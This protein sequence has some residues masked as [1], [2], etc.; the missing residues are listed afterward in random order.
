[1]CFV[2]GTSNT[3]IDLIYQGLPRVPNEGEELY[4]KDFS[5]Q[6]GGG[7]P[8]TLINLG[9][10]G[11]PTRIQTTLGSDMFS[12]F[13][14][15]M[16]QENG[17]APLNLYEGNGIPV[18]V[19]TA[20]LTPGDRTFCSYSDNPTVTDE[21]RDKVYQAS[22]GARVALM[23]FGY[24]DVYQKL[25]DEG[26]TLVFDTGWDDEMSLSSYHEYL[27]LADYYTP[28]Q[29]E[30]LK[31]TGAATPEDAARV[32]GRYFER[33][34]VKLDK[35]GCLISEHGSPRIVPQIPCYT[36]RDSIGAGDAFLA[37]LIYGIYHGADFARS[38]L[39]GNITGGKCVTGVGCLSASCTEDELLQ[40]AQ[41]YLHFIE[42]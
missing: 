29:K 11:V 22:T 21:M 6:L 36:H 32:L 1:M 26:T 37:G 7:V 3:N 19:T 30:A 42:E 38:V 18:N 40:T 15:K 39:Y 28:N 4:A 5:V 24:L 9:R 33:V 41:T 2:A 34:I 23:Q 27:T 17:V 20:M 35:D 31:I 13:A 16:F 12:D 8:A 25:H 10:L 14:R